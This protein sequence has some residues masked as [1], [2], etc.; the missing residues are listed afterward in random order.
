MTQKKRRVDEIHV[1]PANGGS[2]KIY[3]ID[4]S[5]HIDH[6]NIFSFLKKEGWTEN[7]IDTIEAYQNDP[8]GLDDDEML[9]YIDKTNSKNKLIG[10]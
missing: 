2:S 4:E 9:F 3:Y 1:W 10:V 5:H 8:T 6:K 7:S